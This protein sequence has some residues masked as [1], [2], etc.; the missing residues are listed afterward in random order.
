MLGADGVD[1][2]IDRNFI[3][4]IDGMEA[5]IVGAWFDIENMDDGALGD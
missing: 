2:S 3:A 1:Y 5:R 4:D